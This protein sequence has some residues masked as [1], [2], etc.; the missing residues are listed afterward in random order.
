MFHLNEDFK[1]CVSPA[2]WRNKVSAFLNN[3][4]GDG[5]IEIAKPDEPN[6]GDPPIVRIKWGNF[7]RALAK[8]GIALLQEYLYDTTASD[9]TAQAQA[10]AAFAPKSD[11]YVDEEVTATNTARVIADNKIALMG[12]ADRAAREDHR[13]PLET[14]Q[15]TA[16]FRPTSGTNTSTMP[17]DH[18]SQNFPTGAQFALKTDEWEPN[19][20]DGFSLLA[21]SRIEVDAGEGVHAMFFREVKYSK[22]G[23]PIKVGAEVGA[24]LILA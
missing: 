13:H 17:D 18:T 24:V 3:L 7:L 21:I 15:G 1:K 20:T 10:L 4:C 14:A 16:A 2:K 6:S 9:A 19:D 8:K 5:N 23:N 11:K 12:T 22:N